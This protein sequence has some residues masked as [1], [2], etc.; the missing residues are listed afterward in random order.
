MLAVVVFRV[1]D[2]LLAAIIH[3]LK[4]KRFS[5]FLAVDSAFH[6]DNFGMQLKITKWNHIWKY[7]EKTESLLK[8]PDEKYLY[9]QYKQASEKA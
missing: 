5:I 4:I 3:S 6:I 9:M 8:T 1:A 2:S 7:E